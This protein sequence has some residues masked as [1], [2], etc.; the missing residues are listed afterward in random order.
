MCILFLREVYLS[1]CSF[2]EM[3]KGKVLCGNSTCQRDANRI[4]RAIQL[5]YFLLR[6]V[7]N[8]E[9]RK[10]VYCFVYTEDK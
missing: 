2:L 8:R 5:H 3:R 1:L 7:Q 9:F 4:A 6:Q 10:L